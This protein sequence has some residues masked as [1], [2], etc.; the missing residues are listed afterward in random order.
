MTK[1]Q[2]EQCKKNLE[3]LRGDLISTARQ[4]LGRGYIDEYYESAAS[5]YKWLYCDGFKAGF[6]AG[7]K[8]KRDKAKP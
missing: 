1:A 2:E 8:S 3:K 7:K 5:D 4:Q 6:R